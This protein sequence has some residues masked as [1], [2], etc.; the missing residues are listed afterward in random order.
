MASE[1]TDE[2]IAQSISERQSFILDAG[3]G[4]GK[5]SSLIRTLQV[6]LRDEG[7]RLLRENKRIVCITYTNV[8]KDEIE[9]RINSDPRI[10]VSTIHEFLWRVIRSFQNEMRAEILLINAASKRPVDDLELTDTIIEYS[11]GYR[12]FRK[13]RLSH[14][15]VLVLQQH[16]VMAA[17]AVV[18]GS[19]SGLASSSP[20]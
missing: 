17:S 8:A 14:D 18:A 16:F 10:S 20:L 2:L 5:T 9:S 4:S 15:D 3:A 1:G 19:R 13:G 6:I 12:N 11:E 7:E